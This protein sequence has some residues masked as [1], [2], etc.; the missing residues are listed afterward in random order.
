MQDSYDVVIVGGAMI[1]AS[2]AWHL[3]S[4]PGFDGRVLVVG[5]RPELSGL[6]DG[7]Y[8]QLYPHAVLD[9][10]ERESQSIWR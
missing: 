7:A 3:I 4:D 9:P 6:F 5:A 1:G 8:E 10:A 2:V